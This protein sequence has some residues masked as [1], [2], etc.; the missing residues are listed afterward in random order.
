MKKLLLPLLAAHLTAFLLCGCTS[1]EPVQPEEQVPETIEEVKEPIVCT[2]PEDLDLLDG[3]VSVHPITLNEYLTKPESEYSADQLAYHDSELAKFPIYRIEYTVD[4]CTVYAHLTLPAEYD[5]E[6]PA[7]LV[8]TVDSGRGYRSIW[9]PASDVVNE[10]H[11]PLM[12]TMYSKITEEVIRSDIAEDYS[13]ITRSYAVLVC[14]LRETEPGTGFDEFGGD[15]VNDLVFWFDKLPSLSFIDQEH[16]YMVGDSRGA[17]QICLA[18]REAPDSLIRAALSF[19]G[20]YDIADLYDFREDM[21][22]ELEKRIGG[23]P[24]ECPE[25]YAKRS[26]I[27]FAN[28]INTP[29]L[30]VHNTGDKRVPYAQAAAFAEKLTQAGKTVEFITRDSDGHILSGSIEILEMLNR[31]LELYG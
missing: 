18:L 22:D 14:Y 23:T 15:D 7:P 17:M 6:N 10:I 16:I 2:T 26:V 13:S 24:E 30:L 29:L 19:S 21:R 9:N 25:E 31:M 20:A 27:N 4:D 11:H 1:D 12:A 8:I 3:I 5:A 28:E